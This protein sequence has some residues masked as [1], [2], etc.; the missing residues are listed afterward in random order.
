MR[1]GLSSELQYKNTV[2]YM[3][4]RYNADGVVQQQQTKTD[5]GARE[6]QHTV[7][8]FL[9]CFNDRAIPTQYPTQK[10]YDQCPLRACWLHD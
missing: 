9:S 4:A 7:L 6:S 2:Q 10:I 8:N 5:K 3:V 1:I